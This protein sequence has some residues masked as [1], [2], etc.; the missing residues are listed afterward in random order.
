MPQYFVE[1][2]LND[3]DVITIE[4]DD[5]RHLTLVRRSGEGDE[6]EVRDSEGSPAVAMIIEKNRHRIR[7]RVL[8]VRKGL[9]ERQLILA[10][11]LIKGKNLDYAIQKAVE[12]GVSVIMPVV[13]ER[14]VVDPSGKEE[15]KV[16]RWQRI[17]REAAKQCF[18]ERIPHVT[19]IVSFADAVRSLNADLRL[20]A[21]PL[22]PVSVRDVVEKHPGTKKVA[23]LVG[24]EGGFSGAEIALAEDAGWKA[25][26]AGSRV[27]RAETAAC[28]IP[29]IVD[30]EISLHGEL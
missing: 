3:G 22:A 30:Y 18:A 14:S 1:Q 13:S 19:E 27:M 23:I 16:E 5:L 10:M 8:S 12:V 4:G 15:A 28:V 17:A 2:I 7:A 29:A 20:V 11:G 6:I 24:P 21:H 9:G 25:V 26:K